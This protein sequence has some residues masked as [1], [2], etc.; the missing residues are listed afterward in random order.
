MIETWSNYN[1]IGIE[2]NTAISLSDKI[3]IYWVNNIPENNLI[4]QIMSR[5]VIKHV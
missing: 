3:L 2:K 5:V 1:N 4:M